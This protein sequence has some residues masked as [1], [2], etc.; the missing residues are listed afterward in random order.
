MRDMVVPRSHIL[1]RINKINKIESCKSIR[2][3]L[4][5]KNQQQLLNKSG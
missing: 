3:T 1:D 4:C 2:I 5:W